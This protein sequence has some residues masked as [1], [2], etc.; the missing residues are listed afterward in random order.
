MLGTAEAFAL[1]EEQLGDTQRAA[2]T[3]FVA[4]LMRRLAGTH[5]ASAQLWEVVGLCH[6]LDY[7][8]TKDDPS[9]HGLLTTQWLAGR[10]PEDALRAIAAHDH[11]TG[12]HDDT[13]LADMLKL[14]D[15]VAVIEGRLGRD[16]VRHL[17]NGDPYEA[18][19][20]SL[21][22]RGY[23]VDMLRHLTEKH[24]VP[25]ATLASFVADGPSQ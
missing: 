24:A 6:D 1:V 8:Q 14:A 3:R 12:V 18:L 16:V 21:P 17:G 22:E 20:S 2:H 11:R 7:F 15:V 19:R 9:Q 4:Y 13:L 5:D 25:L 23:L 10:L